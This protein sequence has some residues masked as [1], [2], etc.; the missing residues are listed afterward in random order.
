MFS[1][2]FPGQGSLNWEWEK[3]F[4]KFITIIKNIK[5][6]VSAPFHCDLMNNATKIMTEELNKLNFKKWTK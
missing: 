5:L 4:M 6:P 1:V 2:I 3:S